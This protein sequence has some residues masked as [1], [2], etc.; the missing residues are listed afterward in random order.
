[1]VSY[2]G[3]ALVLV[4]CQRRIRFV[5]LA[6]W[7]NQGFVG[8]LLR[9]IGAVTPQGN[10]AS[11]VEQALL[12]AGEALDH[13]EVICLFAES[14]QPS[15]GP[16]WTFHPVL[17]RAVAHRPVRAIAV[18]LPQPH[19]SVFGMDRGQLASRWPAEVPSPVCVRFGNP[20]PAGTPAITVRQALQELSAR[21]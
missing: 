12:R 14:C 4:A 16:A 19:G 15:E 9:R 17:E 8:W 5:I 6:G 3:W 2:F 7:T 20:L 18:A 11:A 13:G 1:P 10:S 21:L